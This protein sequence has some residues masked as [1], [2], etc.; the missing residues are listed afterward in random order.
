MFCI[1]PA[2]GAGATN[3][4]GS[5]VKTQKAAVVVAIPFAAITANGPT[6][7]CLGGKVTLSAIPGTG[8]HYQWKKG[9]T[10]LLGAINS[11]Y[12]AK[13]TGSFSVVVTD[14][15]T[16]SSQSPAIA[17]TGPPTSSIAVTGSLNVC[18]GDSVRL[19]A[20]T[21]VG[22][23]YQ[24]QKSS[25]NI[26][27]ATNMIFYGKTAGVYRVA[28][29]DSYSCT[30][31]SGP[32]TITNNCT[33]IFE[34][35]AEINSP[36]T[37]YPNPFTDSFNIEMNEITDAQFAVLDITG[38]E[39][40]APQQVLANE[41]VSTGSQLKPGIYFLRFVTDEKSWVTRLIKTK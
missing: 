8:Y 4:S 16:C 25:A 40:I 19:R 33:P 11:T 28:I 21:G 24:W 10:N 14:A 6:Q 9:T 36:F 20:T 32:R 1:N 38:K 31:Y 18:N 27:G 26:Q 41:T 15:H 22:Y 13:T 12:L 35:I 34:K 39:V 7:F 5:N 29:T 2:S 37:V 17:V 30:N 3:A 23:T